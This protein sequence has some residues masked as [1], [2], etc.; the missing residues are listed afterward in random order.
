MKI[1]EVK[2]GD[3]VKITPVD[4]LPNFYNGVLEVQSINENSFGYGATETCDGYE[5]PFYAIKEITKWE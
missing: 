5:Y 3:K 1:S 4:T 2:V